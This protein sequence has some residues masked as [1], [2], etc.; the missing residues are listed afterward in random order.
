MNHF[1]RR[2]KGYRKYYKIT[3]AE[4]ASSMGVSSQVI[5]NWERGYTQ[6]NK[7]ELYSLAVNLGVGTDYLLGLT[8]DPLDNSFRPPTDIIDVLNSNSP[9]SCGGF[10]L[11]DKDK[12]FIAN[13][14]LILVRRLKES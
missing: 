3:Q 10:G 11:T 7:D 4:L 12:Q 6:P 8:E 2:L 1:T 5:S 13:L 14:L 9:V